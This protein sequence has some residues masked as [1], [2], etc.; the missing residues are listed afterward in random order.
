MVFYQSTLTPQGSVYQ[1]LGSFNLKEVK[2]N[3]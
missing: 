2:K 3:G 1:E